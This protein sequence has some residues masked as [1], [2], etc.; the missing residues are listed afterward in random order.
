M[1]VT[2]L[3][4]EDSETGLENVEL[5]RIQTI[6]HSTPQALGTAEYMGEEYNVK[7]TSNGER[8]T[9]RLSSDGEV[10]R[11]YTDEVSEEE[12][13]YR[14]EEIVEEADIELAYTGNSQSAAV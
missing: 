13:R 12:M 10:Y 1:S 14:F 11:G 8:T 3:L 4:E 5:D 6:S 7:V 2:Q 9:V